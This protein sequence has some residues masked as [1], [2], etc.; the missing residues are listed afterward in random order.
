MDVCI[1]Q[2]CILNNLPLDF[3]YHLAGFEVVAVK[4]VYTVVAVSLVLT[5]W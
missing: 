1:E 2:L 3:P 4:S 5:V